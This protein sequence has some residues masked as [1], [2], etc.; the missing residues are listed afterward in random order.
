MQPE[1]E[2]AL[3]VDGGFV[4]EPGLRGVNS[5]IIRENVFN[6]SVLACS[7]ITTILVVIPDWHDKPLVIVGFES[8]ICV[9]LILEFAVTVFVVSVKLST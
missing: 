2:L 8:S 3:F 7:L 6:M 4:D 5:V 1:V 9:T